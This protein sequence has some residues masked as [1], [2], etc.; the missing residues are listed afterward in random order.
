MVYAPLNIKQFASTRETSDEIAL[1]IFEIAEEGDEARIWES[2][3]LHEMNEVINKAWEYADVSET[4]LYWGC[5][6]IKRIL[7]D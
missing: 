6:P 7:K 5:E 3:T 2:P 1:A 4:I